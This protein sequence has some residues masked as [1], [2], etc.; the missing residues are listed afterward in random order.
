MNY[1]RT[2]RHQRPMSECSSSPSSACSALTPRKPTAVAVKTPKALAWTRL[3]G[4]RPPVCIRPP[5]LST[6][7]EIHEQPPSRV[8]SLFLK[9]ALYS[10]RPTGPRHWNSVPAEAGQPQPKA[11]QGTEHKVPSL[12]TLLL[13]LLQH[14]LWVLKDTGLIASFHKEFM[15]LAP[16]FQSTDNNR[17]TSPWYQS[18]FF[19]CS[20][21]V[22]FAMTSTPHGMAI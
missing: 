14:K 20:T 8:A 17:E 22:S 3:R 19:F 4:C 21:L 11:K 2:L 18:L 5:V 7:R 10:Y 13:L 16:A 1:M 15:A 12:L 6:W 9:I